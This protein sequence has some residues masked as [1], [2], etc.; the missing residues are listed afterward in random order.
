MSPTLTSCCVFD[1]LNNQIPRYNSTKDLKKL[2]QLVG[3]WE[4]AEDAIQEINGNAE[5]LGIC[6]IWRRI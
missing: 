2:W 3:M 1:N 5:Q 6:S 4:I